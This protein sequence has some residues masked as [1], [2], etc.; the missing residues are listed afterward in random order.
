MAVI[1]NTRLTS[2]G[3]VCLDFDG[4][5]LTS[6]GIVRGIATETGITPIAVN[7][8]YTATSGQLLTVDV[9]NGILANDTFDCGY[10]AQFDSGFNNGFN[11]GT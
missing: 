9:L 6:G 1:T 4:N 5:R 7:D 10:P 2:S 11:I 3:I 8:A